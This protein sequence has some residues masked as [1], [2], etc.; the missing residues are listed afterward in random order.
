[1]IPVSFPAERLGAVI[2]APREAVK[3]ILSPVRGC[4]ENTN[5]PQINADTRG[6][7][8]I[9]RKLRRLRSLSCW[10]RVHPRSSA[11]TSLSADGVIQNE[12][13][14]SD[15]FKHGGWFFPFADEV[16]GTVMQERLAKPVD[17]LLG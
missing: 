15:G 14:D 1:M 5:H 9:Q 10:I 17:L 7:G 16:T 12:E 6:S 2:H 3:E 8:M 11:A 13:N 4:E